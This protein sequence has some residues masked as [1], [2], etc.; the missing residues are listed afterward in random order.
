[1]GA[2][3]T[4]FGWHNVE[5]TWCFPNRR[6]G[7]RGL[8]SQLRRISAVANVVPLGRALDALM[9]GDPLPP[10]AVALC[11][12]DGYRD[13][14]ELAVP[15]LEKLGLPGTFFLVPS[16]LSGQRC[17]WWEI[18]G[19]AFSRS[20]EKEVSWRGML[21]TTRGAAGRAAYERASDH[22]RGLS[23]A[24][25]Q[26]ALDELVDR[27]APEGSPRD[28]DLFLDWDGAHQ[29]VARGFEVGSHTMSHLNLATEPAATQVEDLRGSR[30]VLEKELDR[31]IRV[32]AYPFGQPDAV[33]ATTQ[34]AARE[35]GYS[36]ALTTRFGQNSCATDATGMHR[37]MLDPAVGLLATALDR[38]RNRVLPAT[39]PVAG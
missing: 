32:L 25:R 31:E 6:S 18:A 36:H 29:L 34:A 17:A 37:I 35:A 23:S 4:V 7:V 21:L 1:M 8:E 27:L 20:T 12:D 26:D 38:V 30:L 9:A 16:L 22:L 39:T 19:W 14:L 24:T 13:N 2:R 5:P 3:L 28:R 33:S 10:R 11:W 15:L